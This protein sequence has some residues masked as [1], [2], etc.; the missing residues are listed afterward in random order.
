MSKREKK[1]SHWII[2]E[3]DCVENVFSMRSKQEEFSVCSRAATMSKCC[4]AKHDKWTSDVRCCEWMCACRVNNSF[5][6]IR[7]AQL[8]AAVSARVLCH[9][10]NRT[11]DG[12]IDLKSNETELT[13]SFRSV[14]HILIVNSSSSS[15]TSSQFTLFV[16]L[17]FRCCFV[18]QINFTRRLLTHHD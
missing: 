16:Q 12:H 8:D 18:H 4:D 10:T 7:L 13:A 17:H 6:L 5:K 11:S 14:V 1:K 15:S 2:D 3:I 9:V